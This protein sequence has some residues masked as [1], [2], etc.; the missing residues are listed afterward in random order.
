[1][2]VWI[3]FISAVALLLAFDL[4]VLNKKAHA[5]SLKEATVW[6]TFW[7]A[8]GLGFSIVVYFIYKNGWIGNPNNL[9][10]WNATIKYITGYLVELS[11]SMDNIFVIAVIFSSFAIPEKY[12]H[13]VLFWGIVGA[14]LFRIGAIYLGVALL[15]KFFWITYI[16][17]GFLVFT[18]LRLLRAHQKVFDPKDSLVFRWVNMIIPVSHTIESQKFFIRKDSVL[19]AT[20]LLL[21]LVVI[22]FTDILFA[23]DSIPA[24]LGITS[25]TFLV[26][27]SNILAVMGLRS[28]YFFLSHMVSRF[29]YL[30]YSLSAILFFVGVKL[31]LSHHVELPEWVSLTFIAVALALGVL[32]SLKSQEEGKN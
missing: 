23:L 20:P 15:K 8:L 21:A 32:F 2:T 18:A 27:S 12:Q 29:K 3:I 1:M 25:D 26:F 30:K 22:E 4:G 11:L 28:I 7:M 16:F 5:I 14:I 9:T 10:A 13:R 24:V 19:M 31:I 6:S 17:G